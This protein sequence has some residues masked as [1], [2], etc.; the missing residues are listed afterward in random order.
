MKYPHL[1]I[2]S[3]V[4]LGGVLLS[5]SSPESDG[6][7]AAKSFVESQKKSLK[8][9]EKKYAELLDDFDSYNFQTRSAVRD[10]MERIDVEAEVQAEKRYNEALKRYE[11]LQKKYATSRQKSEEFEY[12]FNQYREANEPSEDKVLE[13]QTSLNRRIELIVPAL[14]DSAQLEYDLVGRQITDQP[15]GYHHRGWVW[16]FQEGDIKS[17]EI[18]S[19]KKLGDDACRLVAEI[20]FQRTGA[21]QKATVAVHY[22]LRDAEDWKIDFIESRSLEVVRTGKYDRCVDIEKRWEG[23]LGIGGYVLDFTNHCDVALVVGGS[24]LTESG[25]HRFS[26]VVEGSGKKSIG[27]GFQSYI[28]DYTVAFIERP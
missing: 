18:T 6:I 2:L 22:V 17:I 12:A 28:K 16:E 20:V 4:M 10:Y 14:P 9:R 25:W 15:D 26:T 3:L 7:E 23:F 21:A 27:G 24:V 13:L 11:R 5:C 19:K 8:F 1:F